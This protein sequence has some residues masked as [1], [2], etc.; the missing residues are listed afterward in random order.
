MDFDAIV[1]LLEQA[2]YFAGSL[3]QLSRDTGI[4]RQT[5]SDW[6]KMRG[7]PRQSVVLK[8]AE[9]VRL[10]ETGQIPHKPAPQAR[11]RGQ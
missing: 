4:A 2:V 8:L 9:W 3:K 5:F 6:L 11:R 7:T 1:L 10:K